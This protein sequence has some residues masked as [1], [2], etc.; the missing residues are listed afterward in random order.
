[1]IDAPT[2]Q[3]LRPHLFSVAY[4]MLSSAAEAE[5]AVQDAWLRAAAAPGDLESAR[6]WLTTVVTRICLDRL[7]SARTRRE[8]YVGP[9][10]PEPVPTEAIASAEDA[11]SRRE[12]ITMAFLVLMETLTPAERAAFLL[13]EVFDGDYAEVAQVLETTPAAA[14]QLVHR[15]KTRLSE[16]RPRFQVSPE[17]QEAI[18]SRFFAAVKDGDVEALRRYLADDVVFSADGGGKALAARRPVF[19]TEA[20]SRLMVGLWQ[21]GAASLG[22]AGT[23]WRVEIRSINGEMALVVF[24]HG[25]LN[26]VFVCSIDD[27]DQITAINVVRNPDKLAW[28]NRAAASD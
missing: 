2:F 21:K 11:V 16:G 17:R 7:K 1:M 12:S 4:R 3:S 6:A 15:A 20:V 10:L 19:G 28:L 14:R 13:R 24:L 18:V 9:W 23:S 22:P 26:T 27:T 25:E 5:D 8:T